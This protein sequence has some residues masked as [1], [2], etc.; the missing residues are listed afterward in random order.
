M[1]GALL[2]AP[3]EGEGEEGHAVFRSA[4]ALAQSRFG[5]ASRL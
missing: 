4:N 5:A 1:F 3:D 2:S